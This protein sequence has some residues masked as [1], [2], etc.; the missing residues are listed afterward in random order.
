MNIND[1]ITS[2]VEQMCE[3]YCKYPLMDPPE[4]HTDDWLMDDDDSPCKT[5]PLNRLI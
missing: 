2:V 1:V 3:N 5:C 4:G